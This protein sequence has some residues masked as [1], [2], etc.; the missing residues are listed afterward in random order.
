MEE[1]DGEQVWRSAGARKEAAA[2]N[3]THTHTHTSRVNL[4][5]MNVTQ[6]KVRLADSLK[7]S[8]PVETRSANSA[9]CVVVSHQKHTSS[10][11]YADLLLSRRGVI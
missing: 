7:S 2:S 11:A 3:Y 10:S 1:F 8:V 4:A 5:L 6:W 9:A